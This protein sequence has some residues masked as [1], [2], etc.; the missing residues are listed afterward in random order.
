MSRYADIQ[1]EPI[2]K[3][4]V[5]IQGYQDQEL[6]SLEE[7]I[8]PIAQL[9]DDLEMHVWIAKQNCQAPVDNLT[10]DKSAAIYLYTMEFD[11]SKSFYR[12]LNVAL[13]SENR[14]S[15]VP[16]SSYL[17]LFMTALY[18]LPSKPQIVYRGVKGI[19]LSDKY[20]KGK[21]FAWWGVSSC[22]TTVDV[23]QEEQFL[24]Q[25][26]ERILFNIEC[27]NGQSIK[28]HSYYSDKEEE[29]IL[30]PGSY[31]EVRGH[32]NSG[33]GLRIIQLQEIEPKY[34]LVRPPFSKALVD[35]TNRRE[36]GKHL[37]KDT[38]RDF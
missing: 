23:L 25:N 10:Q 8:K 1:D 21:H 17:K 34:P 15:I 19:D 31:F 27:S 12:L 26:G 33:H 14:R 3:L 36:A 13:R 6:V 11:S 7:S 2:H 32:L 22:T 37:G 9:F 24:G 29:V 16:W 20:L 35:N 38:N 4:L 5:P 18:K 30:M 28:S